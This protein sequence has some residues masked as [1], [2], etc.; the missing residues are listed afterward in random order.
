[1]LLYFFQIKA[2]CEWWKMEEWVVLALL[3]KIV[4]KGLIFPKLRTLYYILEKLQQL[5]KAY[6]LDDEMWNKMFIK[7]MSFCVVFSVSIS[8]HI[9]TPTLNSWSAQELSHSFMETRPTLIRYSVLMAA[10]PD[11]RDTIIPLSQGTYITHQS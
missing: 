6:A 11:R 7:W 9:D 1:M 2:S 8:L 3:T 5:W 4:P 10:M